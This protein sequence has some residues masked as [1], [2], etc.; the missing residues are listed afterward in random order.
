MR[1][2]KLLDLGAPERGAGA[3][4]R[5]PEGSPPRLAI[6]LLGNLS[7]KVQHEYEIIHQ[8]VIPGYDPGSLSMCLKMGKWEMGN[9]E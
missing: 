8:I 2:A 5:A 7:R 6:Y 1:R 3:S 9:G 4:L